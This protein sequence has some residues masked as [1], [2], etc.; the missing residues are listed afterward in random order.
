MIPYLQMKKPI[1]L[2][3]AALILSACTSVTVMPVQRSE[4]L[5]HIC[6]VNNPKVTVADFVPALEEGFQRHGIST[7]LVGEASHTDCDTTLA[8]TAL[9]SWD[10]VTYLSHAELQL[11]RNGA[12]IGSAQYHLKG[13][14]GLALTKWAST[15]DKMNPVIDE[16]MGE[17]SVAQ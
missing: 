17:S 2:A 15:R 16:L 3:A 5:Q 12:V 8:Y 14:G 4:N 1:G 7:S 10:V 13:K 6:I 11:W 9:R